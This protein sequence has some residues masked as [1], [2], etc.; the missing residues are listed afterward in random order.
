MDKP[1]LIPETAS[2]T[3]SAAEAANRKAR[4]YSPGVPQGGV[5]QRIYTVAEMREMSPK[6]VKGR[7]GALLESLKKGISKFI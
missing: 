3:E 5:A 1:D 4:E 7:Y 2:H 6:E